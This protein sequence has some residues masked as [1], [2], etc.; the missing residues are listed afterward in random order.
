MGNTFCCRGGRVCC[1]ER[2]YDDLFNSEA[3]NTGPS[4]FFFF[5]FDNYLMLIESSPFNR[6]VHVQPTQEWD[7]TVYKHS[8]KQGTGKDNTQ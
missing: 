8:S 2:L 5:F 7:V 4:S 1:C 3:L 6:P